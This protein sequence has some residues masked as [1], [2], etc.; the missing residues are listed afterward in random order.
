AVVARP[1]GYDSMGWLKGDTAELF[2]DRSQ[3]HPRGMDK[4]KFANELPVPVSVTGKRVQPLDHS[5]VAMPEV[6]Q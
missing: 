5:P 3:L 1:E 6:P 4:D 2:F